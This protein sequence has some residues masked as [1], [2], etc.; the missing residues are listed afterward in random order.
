MKK[1][2]IRRCL[3]GAPAGV[4]VCFIEAIL[5]SYYFGGERFYPVV[6]AMAERFGGELNAV[7]I[8]TA[9]VLLYGAM[10]GGT[11]VI[12]ENDWSLLRQTLTHLAIVSLA[13]FPVAWVA[14]WMAHSVKGVIVYFGMF[15]VIYFLVWVIMTTI[16]RIQ[17]RK[18]NSELKRSSQ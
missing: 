3:I 4:A 18:I 17:I 2:I 13:T 5:Q 6:P 7:A 10:W 14:Q 8:Q 9:F 11:S 16:S 1:E 12:W 15:F